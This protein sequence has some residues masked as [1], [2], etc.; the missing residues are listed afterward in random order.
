MNKKTPILLIAILSILI[1]S[2]IYSQESDDFIRNRK[3]KLFFS[4]RNAAEKKQSGNSDFQIINNPKFAGMQ[5]E[6]KTSTNRFKILNQLHNNIEIFSASVKINFDKE[7]NVIFYSDNTIK[8]SS[9]EKKNFPI[10]DLV[11]EHSNINNNQLLEFSKVYYPVSEYKIIPALKIIFK[12]DN[13]IYSGIFN[14]DYKLIHK[15]CLSLNKD[16]NSMPATG[17]VFMPDP[18]TS[19][20]TSYGGNFTHN[21]GATNP[22]F[23]AEQV[24]VD[25]QCKYENGTY[26]LEND[27][28]KIVDFAKPSWEVVTSTDGSFKYNRSQVGF[29]QVNA[30]YH[31]SSIKQQ[32]NYYGFND[33]VN[34]QIQVDAD[35]SNGD[36]NSF[37]HPDNTLEYGANMVDS[38]QHVPDAEDAQVLIHEYTHAIIDSYSSTRNTGERY[39]LEEAMADYMAVSYSANINPYNWQHI[40]KW[41]GNNEFWDGRFATSDKCYDNLYFNYSNPYQNTDIWVAPLMDLYFE[42]GKETTDKLVLNTITGLDGNTS[43]EQAALIMM[44][45][46]SLNNDAQNAQTIFNTFKKYCILNDNHLSNENYEYSKIKILNSADFAK[47]GELT[48]DFGKLFNG[49]IA[50]YNINGTIINQH[51]IY[52]KRTYKINSR[53]LITGIFLIKID[54]NGVSKTFKIIKH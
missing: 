15:D 46:D 22:F 36:D 47:G 50:I 41:D 51:E 2:N 24:D 52:S 16:I 34:Y 54:H 29:Q 19:A 20:E 44:K 10:I 32:I 31:L 18:I 27:Y 33:A 45:I 28:V 3:S 48:I 6:E 1:V 17:S 21:Y 26:Y 49:T 14:S 30:F 38:I 9:V 43:M 4:K 37:F 12:E 40:F 5:L 23:E 39:A 8:Y 35:G 7:K 25:I 13:L 11:L 42:I 53:N